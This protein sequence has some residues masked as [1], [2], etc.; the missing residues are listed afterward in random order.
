MANV[1]QLWVHEVIS[2][3]K[4]VKYQYS[5]EQYISRYRDQ[6]LVVK[7]HVQQYWHSHSLQ[8]EPLLI[9]QLFHNQIV[10]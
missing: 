6:S 9:L 10:E 3:L 7:E 4:Q 1:Q 8:T 5:Y 2:V